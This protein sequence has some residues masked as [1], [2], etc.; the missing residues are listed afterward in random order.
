MLPGLAV[1]LKSRLEAT[2][3]SV[4]QQQSCVC[5]QGTGEEAKGTST[6]RRKQD[7]C[8]LHDV[9]P[10]C[11]PWPPLPHRAPPESSQTIAGPVPSFDPSALALPRGLIQ[12]LCP[13]TNVRRDEGKGAWGLHRLRGRNWEGQRGVQRD[14]R[15]AGDHVGYEVTVTWSVKEG[16]VELWGLEA[17]RSDVHGDAPRSLLRP[18]IQE[19]GPRKGSLRSPGNAVRRADG[20]RGEEQEM[21]LHA[22]GK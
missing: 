6:G 16:D 4:D 15:R 11:D 20:G 12:S 9:P 10:L 22:V 19:P 13:T 17:R 18:L 1:A 21:V 2:N 7:G 5:L 8:K 3:G 14:L